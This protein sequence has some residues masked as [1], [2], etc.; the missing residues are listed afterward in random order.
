[1]KALQNAAKGIGGPTTMNFDEYYE[2]LSLDKS[3]ELTMSV[4]NRAYRKAAL[5]NHPDKG[6]NVDAVITFSS[7]ACTNFFIFFSSNVFKRPSK[8]YKVNL[9]KKKN[10]NNIQ[11]S[12][13]LQILSKVPLVWVSGW[14]LLRTQRREL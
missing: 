3:E 9:K 4:L 10:R 1:M 14:L 6:G 7:S 11:L 2:T 5:K 8:S 13:S 12:N